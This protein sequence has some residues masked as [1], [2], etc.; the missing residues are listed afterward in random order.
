M[1]AV[2]RR[3]VEAGRVAKL[4]VEVE[5]LQADVAR[6]SERIGSDG[7]IGPIGG[8]ARRRMGKRRKKKGTSSW[9]VYG[10]PN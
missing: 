10:D 6:L 4:E 3:E 9:S 7:G 2:E 5:R 1:E 8:V